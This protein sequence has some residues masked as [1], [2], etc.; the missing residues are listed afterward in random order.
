MRRLS[1]RAQIPR[2]AGQREDYLAATLRAYRDGKALRPDTAMNNIMRGASDEEIRAPAHF[3]AHT[4]PV[5]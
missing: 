3:L 4:K 1:G 2:L 5:Q